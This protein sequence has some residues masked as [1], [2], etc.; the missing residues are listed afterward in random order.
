V[1]RHQVHRGGAL[2]GA[3]TNTAN[4][5]GEPGTGMIDN[6]CSTHTRGLGTG[7]P[8]SR[9]QRVIRYA[10]HASAASITSRAVHTAAKNGRVTNLGVPAQQCWIRPLEFAKKDRLRSQP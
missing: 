8:A 4:T 2:R 9:I 7:W 6:S 10:T 3:C 1:N 5:E